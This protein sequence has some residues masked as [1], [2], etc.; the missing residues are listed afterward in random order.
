[1]KRSHAAW[2]ILVFL[3][4]LA[5][6]VLFLPARWVMPFV[7]PRL[8]GVA[9]EGVHGLV[10]AG[11]ADEL[12]SADGRALGRLQWRLSR[13]AL[14][15]ELDLRLHLEGPQL[16]A[17]GRLQRDAHDRPVWSEVVLRTELA[18][19]APWFASPLGTPHGTLTLQLSR[20]V[21]QGNWPVELQ[22]QAQWRAA[23]MQTR[24]GRL[25]LG[26]LGL[27]LAAAAGVLRGELRDEGPGPLHVDGHWQAS[28]LGWRL[29]LLLQPRTVDPALRQWLARLGH[30]GP[31][32]SVRLHRRG[33]LAAVTPEPTR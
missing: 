29:D 7:Q 28:P 30:P 12:R 15:G 8:H 16:M 4:L 31:D 10:W 18:A 13:S 11:R 9:L 6:L 32:G 19:W 22:G 5:L 2:L 3:L 25:A 26:N 27:D 21:L 23:A 24:A 17:S 33:G 20:A 1:M 14:W